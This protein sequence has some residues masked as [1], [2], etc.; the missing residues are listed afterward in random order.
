MDVWYCSTCGATHLLDRKECR[1]CGCVRAYDTGEVAAAK[2]ASP[3]PEDTH[4]GFKVDSWHCSVCSNINDILQ[5][6]CRKC[7]TPSGMRSHG[8]AGKRPE[9]AAP[10]T[11]PA[12]VKSEP[13]LRF[14]NGKSRVDL[15][16]AEFIL[17]LGQHFG[18]G[19][20][21]YAEHNWAKGMSWSRCYACAQ[22]HML[23]FW[24]GEDID[25]ET[26]S[27]HVIAAAWNMCALHWYANHGVGNDDRFIRP[28]KAADL[29]DHALGASQ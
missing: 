28:L 25:G 17:A 21:K 6:V 4:P 3:K 26:G 10:E 8:E 15:I 11:Q 16:P 18:A 20:K 12:G 13:G 23:A 9:P 1:A 27:P 22:R 7:E 19:A 2:D 24:N 29:P 14:D 5:P